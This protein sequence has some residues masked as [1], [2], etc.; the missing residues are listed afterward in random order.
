MEVL[1]FLDNIDTKKR[2]YNDL[3]DWELVDLYKNIKPERVELFDTTLYN[4][5]EAWI[6]VDTETLQYAI[7]YLSIEAYIYKKR[8]L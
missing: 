2:F 3:P 7:E 8:L 1:D 5:L 6:P 4:F